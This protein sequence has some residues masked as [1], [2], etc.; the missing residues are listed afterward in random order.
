MINASGISSTCGTKASASRAFVNSVKKRLVQEQKYLNENPIEVVHSFKTVLFS[1]DDSISA[2][3]NAREKIN[4]LLVEKGYKPGN[5]Q[6]LSLRFKAT[7]FSASSN[8][9]QKALERTNPENTEGCLMHMTS[10]G[11]KD[12]FVIRDKETISPK[13]LASFINNSCGDKP[14][15][16]LISACYSGVFLDEESLLGPNRIILTAARNDRTSFGCGVENQYNFWDGCIIEHIESSETWRELSGKVKQCIEEKEVSLNYKQ[17]F[18]Q[19]YI[20]KNMKNFKISVAPELS[21]S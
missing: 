21:P 19:T 20:G 16:I 6:N 10:H 14:T 18:P 1:G 2:F 17:S 9:L 7:E 4:K 8:N 13:S 15:V 11:T 12:G 5:I 3:D